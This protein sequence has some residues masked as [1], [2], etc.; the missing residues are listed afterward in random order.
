MRKVFVLL[1]PTPWP[2]P[3]CCHGGSCYDPV[4]G[5]AA[6]S[7]TETVTSIE[8]A[9]SEPPHRD[10]GTGE[11]DDDCRDDRG[12]F[13]P[14]PTPAPPPPLPHQMAALSTPRPTR[15]APG[16]TMNKGKV[17]FRR[18]GQDPCRQPRPGGPS[19]RV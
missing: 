16:S 12:D 15:T 13:E 2:S 7:S 14:R 18:P 8:N 9:A 17:C 19:P 11:E 6:S 5:S 4:I 1:A 3:P 10:D